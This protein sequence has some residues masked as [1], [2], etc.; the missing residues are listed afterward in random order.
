VSQSNQSRL[1]GTNAIVR[2]CAVVFFTFAPL[3][4]TAAAPAV[5]HVQVAA[6][7]ARSNVPEVTTQGRFLA[8]QAVS[9]VDISA[10]GEFITV[11]TMA[12]SHEA[13]VWQFAP[14]GTVLGRRHFPPWAP[15]QVAT[16]SGGRAMA[17]GL[18]YSRVTSP[19][20]TVWLGPAE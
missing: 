14:D 6:P 9:A 5:R 17:I 7:A 12:F 13:N 16:L 10:D 2:L 11:G 20:P 8:P 18:A 19:D 3:L 1:A 4:G 15:M